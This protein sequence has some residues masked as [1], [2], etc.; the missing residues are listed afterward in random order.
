MFAKG[1]YQDDV[2]RDLEQEEKVLEVHE[3]AKQDIIQVI[4]PSCFSNIIKKVHVTSILHILQCGHIFIINTSFSKILIR[5]LERPI[6]KGDLLASNQIIIKH[7][8]Q[9]IMP[10]RVA[11]IANSLQS[12][13][14]PLIYSNFISTWLAFLLLYSVYTWSNT[15]HRCCNYFGFKDIKPRI[16]EIVETDANIIPYQ[17]HRLKLVKSN[18]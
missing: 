11:D 5:N 7:I 8:G 14:C 12:K 4:Q 17:E 18:A 1:A 10:S 2:A 3:S 6:E 9:H 16:E 13:L 15:R